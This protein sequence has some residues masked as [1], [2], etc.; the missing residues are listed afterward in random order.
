MPTFFDQKPVIEH[1]YYELSLKV[2]Q[3]LVLPMENYASEVI[4][5][6]GN[7]IK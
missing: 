5:V 4:K 2:M 7:T 1:N 3:N 6:N